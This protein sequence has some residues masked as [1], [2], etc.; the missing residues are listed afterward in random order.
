MEN[1]TQFFKFCLVHTIMVRNLFDIGTQ[2]KSGKISEDAVA[3]RTILHYD[4]QF[5]IVIPLIN[6]IDRIFLVFIYYITYVLYIVYSVILS[7][8][9][10]IITTD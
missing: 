5:C 2:D 1:D 4:A 7:L 8:K 6:L 10:E 9:N 3:A